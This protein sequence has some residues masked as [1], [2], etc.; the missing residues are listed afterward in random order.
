MTRPIRFGTDGVRGLAGQWPITEE[1]AERIGR[2]IATWVEGGRVLIGRDTRESGPALQ[3]A[4]SRG[5]MR[6]GSTAVDLGILP[7]AA[8]STAVA[9]DPSAKAGVMLTASHNPW[10]DNGIKVVNSCGEK[11][12][13]TTDLV[14][15]FSHPVDR[16]G[17]RESAHPD[18]LS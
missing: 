15:C 10:T 14:T 7:T 17:G 12:S 2:G 3:A 8:V 9:A 18:P 16:P 13:N 11:P 6:G 5:L 1:G 4:L